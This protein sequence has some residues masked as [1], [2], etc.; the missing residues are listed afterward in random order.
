MGGHFMTQ[1]SL[2]PDQP[3]AGESPRTLEYGRQPRQHWA[4][5]APEEQRRVLLR[6]FAIAAVATLGWWF[7]LFWTRQPALGYF[8]VC[9]FLPGIFGMVWFG[10]GWQLLNLVRRGSQPK[11]R[12]LVGLMLF[13]FSLAPYSLMR[14]GSDMFTLSVRYHLWQAGGADKVRD[15]FNGWVA[16][17]PAFDPNG[18]KWLFE[19]VNPAGNIV[20]VPVA[21]LPREVGYMLKRF[22]SRAGMTS[23]DVAYL[24]NVSVFTTTSIM[25]GPKGWQPDGG[26]TVWNH[27]IGNRRQVGDGIWIGFGV[28]NK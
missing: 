9:A 20:R 10:L 12:R 21:Q 19:E 25:I 8:C 15:A 22:P 16:S 11:Q 2:H 27:L 7:T 24:D 28:Y 5:L 26:A 1:P 13:A 14:A 23:K 18:G 17:R 4:E 3:A 6:L